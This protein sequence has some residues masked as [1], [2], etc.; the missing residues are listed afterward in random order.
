MFGELV[1]IHT[2]TY[3][4]PI[5]HSGAATNCV[6]KLD[7]NKNKHNPSVETV[8]MLWR[9]WVWVH[10][11]DGVVASNSECLFAFHFDVPYRS[12]ANAG[13]GAVPSPSPFDVFSAPCMVHLKVGK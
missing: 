2:H 9:V 10:D 4:Q 3:T 12:Q 1:Y 8:S 6:E 13:G 5:R 7:N 11:V